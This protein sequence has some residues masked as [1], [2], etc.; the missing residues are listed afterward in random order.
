MEARGH[1][2][3]VLKVLTLRCLLNRNMSGSVE[4]AVRY[5]K[6]CTIPI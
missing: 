6:T 5:M 2:S 3:L 4:K 1:A